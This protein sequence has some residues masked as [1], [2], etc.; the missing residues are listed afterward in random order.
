[1]PLFYQ[2]HINHHTQLAIWKIEEGEDF[3]LQKVAPQRGISNLHKRLQHLAA[4]YLLCFLY[5][6]FAINSVDVTAT[7]KPFLPDNKYR[8]SISHSKNY[9]AVIVSKEKNV[10]IDIEMLDNKVEKILHK[11]LSEGEN[12]KML[13][14]IDNKAFHNLPTLLWST[15][16]T[17]FKFYAK[18]NVDFKTML[19]VDI[20]SLNEQSVKALIDIDKIKISLNIFYKILSEVC[21]TYAVES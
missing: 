7:G 1:M 10:A 3:F 18:G 13:K 15:K 17:M 6:D 16:E 4:R 20:D 8:F 19:K 11:F 14:T 12:Q 9:A 2:Q 5:D 21:I